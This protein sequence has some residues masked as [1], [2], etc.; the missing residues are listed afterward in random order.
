M[1]QTQELVL[2]SLGELAR[3]RDRF[4]DARVPDAMALVP[5]VA[6]SGPEEIAA[7]ARSARR[8]LDEL[9]ALVASDRQRR[10][11]AEQCLARWQRLRDESARVRGIAEEMRAAAER[12]T[13]LG[14][15]ALDDAARRAA[16][17][18]AATAGR[19][20]TQA[21]VHAETLA[22]EADRLAERDDV[23]RLLAEE[24]TKEVETELRERLAL[25]GTYLDGGRY[26]EAR[27]LLD[28]LGGQL[29]S[30]PDLERTFETLRR[31]DEAVK[32]R[33]AELAL[34]EARRCHRREP[35]RALD[36]IEPLA[37]DE[38]PDELARHLYGLWLTAC[39]RLG[40]IAA[41]HYRAGFGRGAVLVPA[42]D[43]RWE[44]VSAVGLRG[45]Q[46]GG[47][48]APQALRGARPLA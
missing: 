27:R 41:V 7:L 25:A 17:G 20:A 36:L 18:V 28:S 5:V 19:L 10:R 9:E 30:V 15:A 6:A 14:T 48:F 3:V 43:G 37:L 12:A 34:R 23:S 44:V 29:S 16:E 21:E 42:S 35:A 2:T 46:R 1:T 47:R 40:L 4:A 24:R 45:W 13:G 32:V 31:R 26:N 22:S 38:L 33:T 11:E 39:R 8:A